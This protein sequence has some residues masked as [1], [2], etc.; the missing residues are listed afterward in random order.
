M[1]GGDNRHS[2]TKITAAVGVGRFEGLLLGFGGRS[3]RGGVAA[4]VTLCAY[5]NLRGVDT[6][7]H[8]PQSISQTERAPV[9]TLRF[10]PLASLELVAGARRQAGYAA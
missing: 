7:L 5:L 6:I 8:L 3:T 2:R 10:A 9:I 4:T 1:K